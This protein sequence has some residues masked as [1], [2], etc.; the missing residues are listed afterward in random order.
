MAHRTTSAEKRV[1]QRGDHQRTLIYF[2]WFP[3]LDREA[4]GRQINDSVAMCELSAMR[5]QVFVSL[6]W[7]TL[8][9]ELLSY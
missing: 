4:K 8:F 7:L 6:K 9:G 3:Q 5:R 1:E 2:C